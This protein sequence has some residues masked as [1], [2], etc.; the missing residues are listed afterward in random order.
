MDNR[1]TSLSYQVKCGYYS[2]FFREI[3]WGRFSLF[4]A[5]IV[6]HVLLGWFHITLDIGLLKET[7][8]MNIKSSSSVIGYYG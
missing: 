4:L 7:V 1:L 6:N 3:K 2:L 5:C 8:R